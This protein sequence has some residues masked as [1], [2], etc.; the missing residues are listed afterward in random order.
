[1]NTTY[2]PNQYERTYRYAY[3]NE[4]INGRNH[5]Y[6]RATLIANDKEQIFYEK[7]GKKWIK[8]IPSIHIQVLFEFRQ[9]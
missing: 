8:I 2:E 5:Y 1:M 3:R 6:K 9:W 4:T 7:I